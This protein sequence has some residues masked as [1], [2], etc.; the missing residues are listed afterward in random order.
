M[1]EPAPDK[2]Y[3]REWTIVLLE[4]VIQRL[5]AECEADGRGRQFAAL[6]IFLTEGKRALPYA[7][8]AKL[9]GLEEAA[10][11]A[12]VH[13]LRRRYRQLL[14]EQISQT[15]VNPALVDEEIRSLFGAF[16]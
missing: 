15:L 4:K 11:R 16:A 13:R 6:K 7:S 14:R 3:D 12:A 5:Q 10:A 2:A 8:V 9:I 1:T